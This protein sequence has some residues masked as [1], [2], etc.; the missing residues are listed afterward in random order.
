M[1]K[2]ILSVLIILS[3]TS[4]SD[5]NRLFKEFQP[6]KPEIKK[7]I[8]K[9]PVNPSN[10]RFTFFQ[11]SL[12]W[13]DY[14]QNE[15]L[16][17]K[18][19]SQLTTDK[20]NRHN[21]LK[22]QGPDEYM[23]VLFLRQYNNYLSFT[24]SYKGTLS[25]FNKDTLY[26]ELQLIEF[27]PASIQGIVKMNN[28]RYLYSGYLNNSRFVLIDS[29]QNLLSEFSKF[30]EK[31]DQMKYK[32]IEKNMACQ[33]LFTNNKNNFANIVYDSGIIEFF[34]IVN[35]S[36]IK[37][38]ETV[39]SEYNFSMLYENNATRVS[40]SKSNTGFIDICSDETNVYALFSSVSWEDNVD[41]AYF[42][43]YILVYSW[44]GE[45]KLALKLDIPIRGFSAVPGSDRFWGWGNDAE[46][47]YF[48]EISYTL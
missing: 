35:D 40:S 6:R 4:C 15:F 26:K 18:D 45:P 11:N 12:Y 32:I 16:F 46:G 22:G 37:K 36:I 27:T 24:D 21:I 23:M 2:H 5:K 39:Y 7:Y 38:K 20:I 31:I 3:F 28:N 44:A 8:Q 25:F 30:P 1:K 33:N 19:I 42:G 13:I 17:S 43:D 29:L 14:R 41:L 48:T 10:A 47:I 9:G 34:S